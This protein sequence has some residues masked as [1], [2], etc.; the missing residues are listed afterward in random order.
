MQGQIDLLLFL[1]LG[2][3]YLSSSF[4]KLCSW[5]SSQFP[6]QGLLSLLALVLVLAFITPYSPSFIALIKLVIIYLMFLYLIN[7]MHE[8]ITMLFLLII[9]SL[10]LS[11]YYPFFFC[12]H[13]RTCI[14]FRDRGREGER[15]E[16]KHRS[17]SSGPAH[18]LTVWD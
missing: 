17:V 1:L 3:I 5:L 12:P 4:A 16:E 8:A 10:E 9:L 2:I 15:E 7:Q 11:Q 13:L 14:D 6:Q 18:R